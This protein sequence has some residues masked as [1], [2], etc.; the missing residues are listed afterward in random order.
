MK[1]SIKL[2]LSLLIGAS[3]LTLAACDNQEAKTTEKSTALSEPAPRVMSDKAEAEAKKAAEE[4]TS[5]EAQAAV[6]SELAKVETKKAEP[7]KT[8]EKAETKTVSQITEKQVKA[9]REKPESRY[10]R[11]QKAMLKVLESQYKQV[12]CPADATQLNEYSFCRQEERRLFLEI[13]R[14]KD[15]IRLNQ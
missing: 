13:Q 10:L 5:E 12:R 8:E 1:S 3:V 11:E 15:E 2:A 6:K 7:V 4:A 14:V 9:V